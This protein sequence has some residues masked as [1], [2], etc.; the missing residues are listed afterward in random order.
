MLPFLTSVVGITLG[1]PLYPKVG[2]TAIKTKISFFCWEWNPGHP[3]RIYNDRAR[4]GNEARGSVPV[5]VLCY[6]SKD[7]WSETR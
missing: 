4:P 1:G 7:R 2:L 6:K 5:K 3:A